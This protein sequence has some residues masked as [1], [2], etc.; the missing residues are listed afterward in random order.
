MELLGRGV[1]VTPYKKIFSSKHFIKGWTKERKSLQQNFPS[2]QGVGCVI[3]GINGPLDPEILQ[4]RLKCKSMKG[5][6]K[7]V[8]TFQ[9]VNEEIYCSMNSTL[10]GGGMLNCVCDFMKISSFWK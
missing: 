8:P 10:I 7:L 1:V 5:F 9:T 2:Y 4:T 6:N 3:S